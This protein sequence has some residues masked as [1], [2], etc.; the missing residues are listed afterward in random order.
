MFPAY[1]LLNFCLI[2]QEDSLRVA[3]VAPPTDAKVNHQGVNSSL[4]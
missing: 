4:E 3:L 2:K 1:F